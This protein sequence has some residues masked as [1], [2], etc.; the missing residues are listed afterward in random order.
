MGNSSSSEAVEMVA[1]LRGIKDGWL[2]GETLLT[3]KELGS[4]FKMDPDN[5]QKFCARHDVLPINIGLGK[6]AR[7]RWIGSQVINLLTILQASSTKPQKEF[8]P[9][10]KGDAHILGR[11]VRELYTELSCA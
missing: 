2:N 1:S 9:R 11:S 3:K 8:R 4:F 10:R 7:L 6:V 5:A